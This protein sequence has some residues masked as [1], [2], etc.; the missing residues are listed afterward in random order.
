MGKN[1]SDMRHAGPEYKPDL[2]KNDNRSQP[3]NKAPFVSQINLDLINKLYKQN[4]EL[5]KDN[6]EKEKAETKNLTTQSIPV[7][8]ISRIRD[9]YDPARPNDYE[10][11]LAE[12]EKNRR[13][14]EE[15][16][17]ELERMRIEEEITKSLSSPTSCNKHRY[18][19]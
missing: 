4:K 17:K 10:S 11:V 5:Q 6:P 18:K 16:I 13:K 3:Q 15:R 12:R 7:S 19:E 14:E 1:T 2:L 9:E 8:Q